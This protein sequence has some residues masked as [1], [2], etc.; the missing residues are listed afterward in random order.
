MVKRIA[1]LVA[2]AALAAPAALAAEGQRTADPAAKIAQLRQKLDERFD[3]FASRCLVAQA[4]E[5]C[6]HAASR[7]VHRLEKLQARIDK[8][9]A[10]IHERCSQA[11]APLACANA[12]AVVQQL[13]Q[14]K[15]T[16]AADVARIKAVYPNA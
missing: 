13:D 6:V 1:L 10:R 15:A 14:L 4:P 5:R 12:G 2:V 11:A 9:E 3:R 8:I 16:A 7:F